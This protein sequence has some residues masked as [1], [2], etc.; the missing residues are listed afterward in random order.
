ML[1]NKEIVNRDLRR[2]EDISRLLD[3]QFRIPGTSFRFGLDPILGLLPVAG[4]L[5]TFLI[6]GSLVMTMARH[7][8]S[9]KVVILMMMNV[10]LDAIIGCIPI[11]GQIFDF[12]YKANDRNIK[13]LKKHYQEGKY[14]GTGNGI[15]ITIL[16]ITLIILIVIGYLMFKLL[17]Y[18]YNWVAGLF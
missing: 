6:S 8:V 1:K 7:G 2:V 17:Q 10:I 5:S 9:R 11:I 3:S 16:L 12:T 15:I 18:F 14:Q 4:D 13:L